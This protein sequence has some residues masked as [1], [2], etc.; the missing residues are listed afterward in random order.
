M[1]IES[2]VYLLCFPFLTP[3]VASLI[4]LMVSRSSLP[5]LNSAGFIKRV[6]LSPWGLPLNKLPIN[7]MHREYWQI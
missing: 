1:S 4:R 5:M 6:T 3:D 2:L 7:K